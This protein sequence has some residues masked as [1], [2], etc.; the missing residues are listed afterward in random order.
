MRRPDETACIECCTH[1]WTRRAGNGHGQ[2]TTIILGAG[3]GGHL[4]FSDVEVFLH[5][6]GF[7]RKNVVGHAPD[8]IPFGETV[9]PPCQ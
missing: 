5:L 8:A 3:P 7:G 2:S 9:L 6:F 1:F 4:H